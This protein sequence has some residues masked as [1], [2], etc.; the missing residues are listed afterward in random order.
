MSV[1]GK[2]LSI[3]EVYNVGISPIAPMNG[4]HGGRIGMSQMISSLSGRQ[5]M[6]GY[7]VTTDQHVFNVLI[8]NGQ[9]CCES[10]GCFI[11]ED[12]S[13]PFIGTNLMSVDLTDVALNKNKVKE[14]GY[15]SDG[16]GIQ[17]VDFVTDAGV[18]Q[19]AVYNSHNGY[20]GHG[21]V[22]ARDSDIILSDTL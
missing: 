21:I 22:V 8:D 14:S 9:S 11:S 13:S 18:F 19:L 4:A 17:F 6:N 3:E 1:L 2:I 7:C 20:Y 12:D 16:G 10:W 15:Y 5:N